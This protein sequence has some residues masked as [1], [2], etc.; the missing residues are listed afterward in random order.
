[1]HDTGGLFGNEQVEVYDA[2]SFGIKTSFSKDTVSLVNQGSYGRMSFSF[3]MKVYEF[4]QLFSKT[5]KSIFKIS[6]SPPVHCYVQSS[7]FVH[8]QYEIRMEAHA[9]KLDQWEI[10]FHRINQLS[11]D[12][13]CMLHLG[14]SFHVDHNEVEEL[15]IFMPYIEYLK[16]FV[17][18]Y[19][20][21]PKL[22]DLIGDKGSLY[23]VTVSGA[24]KHTKY[25]DTPLTLVAEPHRIRL[26]D[27]AKLEVVE[28]FVV[29][30]DAFHYSPEGRQLLV[31]KQNQAFRIKLLDEN[32]RTYVTQ[33]YIKPDHTVVLNAG[34]LYGLWQGVQYDG[35]AVDVVYSTS[36]MRLLLTQGMTLTD[37][38]PYSQ[39]EKIVDNRKCFFLHQ[40][41]IG[42]LVLN[43]EGKTGP[44]ALD[45]RITGKSLEEARV[46]F[47]ANMQ[48]FYYTHTEKELALHQSPKDCLERF[49]NADISEIAVTGASS[50]SPF[51]EIEIASKNRKDRVY[52]AYNGIE[53]LIHKAYYYKKAVLLPECNPK[54]LFLS[55][56]RVANDFALYH[57]FGQLMTIEEGIRE[58]SLKKQST[59]SKHISLVNFLYYSIQAQK[60]RMDQIAIYLPALFEQEDRKLLSAVGV[61][62]EDRAYRQF[63][64]QLIGITS[65]LKR[66]LHEIESA[67]SAVS[68]AIIPRV[69]MESFINKKANK[70]Y[71]ASGALMLGGLVFPPLFL[72]GAFM[73]INAY[74]S[75]GDMIMQEEIRKQNESHR[76]QFYSLKALDS[77]DH[78]M[79]TLY[80]Y[81]IAECNRAMYAF[82][83]QVG[84]SYKPVLEESLVKQELFERLGQYYTFKQLPIDDT[85]IMK[86]HDLIEKVHE[87]VQLSGQHIS[88]I[89][90]EVD[91]HVP[92]STAFFK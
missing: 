87:A 73:G 89:K 63:Q 69:E 13:N 1:V 60:K 83:Q 70:R 2:E 71:K 32:T 58:I 74:L 40:W 27:E 7:L 47:L 10:P 75:K 31:V 46:G 92:E 49:L 56:G 38:I 24:I 11:I 37:N 39:L 53:G 33:T 57:L 3:S 30:A 20:N 50:E 14:G 25:H 88:L 68:F 18:Q 64:Q 79:N 84:A 77:F 61:S 86:K 34:K 62:L 12:P 5:K 81:Y 42:L 21:S 91:S 43:E 35:E 16:Q 59:E 45:S 80:P 29:Q 66:S 17:E 54:Q 55:W 67:L 90:Q 44:H 8:K 82:V 15:I 28:E 9:F 23:P 85:V 22:T 51:V 4:I 65:Q 78:L 6:T 36:G 76:L 26:L 19:N 41:E 48:P 72:A 52:V